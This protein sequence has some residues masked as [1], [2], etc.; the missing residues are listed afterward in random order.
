MRGPKK[1]D[2]DFMGFFGECFKSDRKFQKNRWFF[3]F[4]FRIRAH[5]YVTLDSSSKDRAFWSMSMGPDATLP[6]K[7]DLS[8]GCR[9][10]K[11][12]N[13]TRIGTA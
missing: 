7:L 1:I 3:C 10:G 11:Y 4:H 2:P 9:V 13:G 6:A 12:R 5:S 8:S